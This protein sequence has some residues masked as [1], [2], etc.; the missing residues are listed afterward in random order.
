MQSEDKSEGQYLSAE[1]VRI[2]VEEIVQAIRKHVKDPAIIQAIYND[3]KAK[4]D[5]PSV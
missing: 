1:A 3:I 4:Q 5:D 2:I